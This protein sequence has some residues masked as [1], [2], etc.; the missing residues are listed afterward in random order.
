LKKKQRKKLI[1]FISHATVDK[2]I[3]ETIG[4]EITY[5]FGKKIFIFC[6][7]IPGVIPV[8]EDWLADIEDK[9]KKSKVCLVLIT[10]NSIDRN[11]LWFEL[12]AF[13]LKSKTRAIKIFPLCTS[14]I[15]LS[16]IPSPLDRLQAI[17]FRNKD[18]ID[19]LFL[20][21]KRKFS[22][23]RWRKPRIS[24]LI[25]R[26]NR[27]QIKGGRKKG[28]FRIIRSN[29]LEGFSDN[30]LEEII[31]EGI[32]RPDERAFASLQYSHNTL[33]SHNDLIPFGRLLV[34][35]EIDTKLGLPKGTAKKLL[36][37]VAL[38]ANLE[39][40]LKTRNTIRFKK[41]APLQDG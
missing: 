8:G 28:E 1:L 30:E 34:F 13:W 39:P 40:H 35:S 24:F 14:D 18:E 37:K 2:K 23:S 4:R 5:V 10:S 25:K 33:S 22:I 11:W 19:E 29:E 21:L 41:K 27:Y 3:A 16:K 15:D 6:T 12:G 20:E 9:L 38:K 31:Y 7:S 32:F 36:E 26:I 17:T